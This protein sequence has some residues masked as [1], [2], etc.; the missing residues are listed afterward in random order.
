GDETEDDQDSVLI[1]PT[2]LVADLSLTKEV[3]NGNTTPLVGSQIAFLISVTNDG[4]QDAT[5]VEIVDLLP[6]G[7]DYVSF[8]TS[9]GTY[10]NVTGVWTAGTITNGATETLTINVVVNETGDYLNI[11]EVTASDLPD[12]DS[13]P[14]NGDETEDDQDSVLITPVDFMADLSLTKTV[15][16]GND[17]PNVGDQI[18]FEITVI[19]DGP[20]AATGVEVVDLLPAGFS[21]LVYS[22]TS[23]TYNQVTGLWTVGDIPNGGT[24]TL[25]INVL[26]NAPTGTPGEYFNSA[27]VTAS[28]IADPDSTPN[29]DDGTQSEDDEDGILIMTETADLSLNKSVSNSNANVGE[30]IT[31]TLQIDN[32][33]NST[34]TGVA[35]Q[36][37]L[38]IGYSNI[39]NISNGGLLFGSVIDW[40]NL[41]VPLTGLTLTYQATVNLPTLAD[42]EYLNIAQITASDQF[43]PDSTPNNDDGDQSE[44]DEDSTF[45]NT[46]T[47]DIEVIKVVN[48]ENP[49]IADEV[50]FTITA[51]NL[52]GLDA[53]T[54]EIVDVLPAGYEFVSY[55]ATS[56]TYNNSTGLWLIPTVAGGETETLD[57]TVKVLDI[58]DYLNIA[59]LEYL[60]QIDSNNS[61]DSDDAIISPSCLKIYNEFSPNGNGKNE[62]FYIDCIN[63]YP[64]NNLLIYNRWGNLVY[65]KDG[66]D[67]TFNGESNGRSVFN[68]N[69]K[70]PV[71]TYYYILDLGDGSERKSGWLYL[72]R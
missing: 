17:T 28:D 40:A 14:N 43:D 47:T 1:T 51:A 22:S 55:N 48:N 7:F 46:P 63:N 37:I 45:I 15:V 42:D 8:S 24:Q 70:L 13:T 19:N 71:G 4:P 61:N 58:S 9:S 18:T 69:E 52:G 33:G 64:N 6:S 56:G 60:D 65:S 32:G 25:L 39:T 21:Y 5:G 54:V 11:A 68:K 72:A 50:I 27:Q 23:G 57:I 34:A 62:F 49:N 38:P 26:V 59:S 67:N 12:P 2:D 10:N 29:N 41:T 16:N 30:V 44:D 66:Y 36:D 35:V 31:F 20:N 53:T 3:V